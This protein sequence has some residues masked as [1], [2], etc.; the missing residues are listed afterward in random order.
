[1][2]APQAP[3]PQLAGAAGSALRWVWLS[4]PGFRRNHAVPDLPSW[5]Y[6]QSACGIT[7]NDG[8]RLQTATFADCHNCRR[9]LRVISLPPNS[10]LSDGPKEE[11]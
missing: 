3:G 2:S 8:W 6:S 5:L 9:H 10:G 7:P 1:M 11:R 4:A